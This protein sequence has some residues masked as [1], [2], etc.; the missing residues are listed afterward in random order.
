M[1]LKNADKVILFQFILQEKKLKLGFS[2]INFAKEIIKNSKVQLFILDDRFQLAKFIKANIWKKIV[3][4][5]VLVLFQV[6]CEN[7]LN[8]YNEN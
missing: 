8:Y 4:E 3:I 2:Y 1:L 6:G 5:W 7:Y